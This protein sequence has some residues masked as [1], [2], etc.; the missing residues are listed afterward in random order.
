MEGETVSQFARRLRAHCERRESCRTVVVVVRSSREGSVRNYGRSRISPKHRWCF[1]RRGFVPQ[2]R[3]RRGPEI[4]SI[5]CVLDAAAALSASSS[6]GPWKRSNGTLP[7]RFQGAR[8]VD[9][10]FDDG[11]WNPSTVR[12]SGRVIEV[13]FLVA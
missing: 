9:A 6:T 10:V 1:D 11:K 13:S 8:C 2:S 3:T 4:V 5:I 7:G 12:R